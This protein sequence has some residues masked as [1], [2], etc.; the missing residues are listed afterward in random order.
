MNK[1]AGVTR[2]D[3]LGGVLLGAGSALLAGLTPRELLAAKAGVQLPPIDRAAAR[4]FDGPSGVGDYQGVNGNTWDVLSRAHWIRDGYFDEVDYGAL[5]VEEDGYDVIMVGGGAS[6]LGAAYLLDRESSLK[7]LILENH[8]VPGG[9]ARQNEFEVDGHRIFGPQGSNLVV[10]PTEPGQVA[11]GDDLLYDEF[12]DIGMPLRYGLEELQG[13]D[14]ALEFDVSNY[15]YLWLAIVSDS[16]GY[17]SAPSAANRRPEPVRNPWMKDLEGLGLPEAVRQDFIRWQWRLTLDRERD[18]SLEPWLDRMSYEQLLV[19]VHG[20]SPAIAR[21][22]DPLV[23]S[24]VGAGSGTCS[25][26]VATKLMEMPGAALAGETNPDVQADPAFRSLPAVVRGFNVGCFPGGNSFPYRYFAKHV[27]PEGI[28]GGKNPEDVLAGRFNSERLDHRDN[29][30]RL[31]TGATVIDVRHLPGSNGKR[32]RVVYERDGELHAAVGRS[33]IVCAGAWVSRSIL[34]DAPAH[35]HN[36]LE[37]FVHVPYL[38]A[39]VALTNWRFLERL[40]ITAAVY[41]GGEFGFTCNIRQPMQVGGYRAPL[42]PDKPIVLTFYAS[43]VKPELPAKVQGELLRWEMFSTAYADYERRIRRQMTRL[44]DAGGFDPDRDIAGITLNR[45]GHAYNV[46]QPGFFYPADGGRSP[47]DQLRAGYGRIF[48]AHSELRGLQ[49][50]AGANA[51]GYRAA[52]QV[53]AL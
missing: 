34:G 19:D 8:R 9:E 41:Q 46:P 31:R 30:L 42:H 51:E 12:T 5:P 18:D 26:L 23:A 3:Y 47:S 33:A 39:N 6:S 15:I 10:L 45:W 7:G 24:A 35:I 13:T 37:A 21:F 27:W 20:L 17:Y 14:K 11:L 52:R 22:A 28:A 43:L 36:A 16:I 25:A 44:F 40:G 53:M 49:A 48:F 29:R 2:R 38:V 4:R 50:F 1:D 32:V